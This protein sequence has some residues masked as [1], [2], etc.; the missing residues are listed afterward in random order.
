MPV[1]SQR[2]GTVFRAIVHKIRTERVTFLAGSIAYNAFLSL[3]PLLF[4]IL[5]LVTSVGSA[6]LEATLISVTRTIITPGASEILISELETVSVSISVL[7]IA[8]LVWGALRIFRSLDTAFSGIYES[9]AENTFTNQLQDGLTVLVSIVLIAGVV[10]FVTARVDLTT[11]TTV[12]WLLVRGGLFALLALTLVPMF[13]LFPDE[14]DMALIEA[15]PGA[16]FSAAGLMALQSVFDLY[17]LVSDPQAQNSVLASLI[18][19]LTWLYFAA[20]V[21]LIGATTS[22]VLTNRSTEVQIA[23][24]IAGQA[25]ETPSESASKIQR[26]TLDLVADELVGAGVVSLTVDGVEMEIPPP[27]RVDTDTETSPLPFVDNTVHLTVHWI[28]EED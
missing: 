10:M 13:Y 25:A 3:L 2:A 19:L 17:L 23:P 24:V 21:I 26:E 14:T 4:L 27:E 7:G 22:A 8:V 11:E 9:Q 6:D 16:V 15:V 28:P 5:A 12:G 20:L 1:D 18:I